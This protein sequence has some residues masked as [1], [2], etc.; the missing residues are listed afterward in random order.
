[1]STT[2]PPTPCLTVAHSNH[3]FFLST[4]YSCTHPPTQKHRAE[5]GQT[6]YYKRAVKYLEEFR[7][8]HLQAER[9]VSSLPTHPPT[10]SSTH[11]LI[12]PTTRPPLHPSIHPPTHPPTYQSIHPPTHPP[13]HPPIHPPTHPPTLPYSPAHEFNSL[14]HK[15]KMGPGEG[16]RGGGNAFWQKVNEAGVTLL[17]VGGW[18]G[19]WVGGLI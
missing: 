14:L 9:S 3:L 2:H 11:L 5:D 17:E 10:S 16:G 7:A 8:A 1:M 12:Y 13:T 6:A 19:G 18:V 4:L 15:I